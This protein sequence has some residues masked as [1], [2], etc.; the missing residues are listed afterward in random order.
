MC[1]HQ[2]AG[3]VQIRLAQV[4]LPQPEGPTMIVVFSGSDSDCNCRHSV[5]GPA[6]RIVLADSALRDQM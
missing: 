2:R 3:F 5:P 6:S 1:V 4:D